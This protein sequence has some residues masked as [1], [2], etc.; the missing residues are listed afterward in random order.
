[1]TITKI[2]SFYIN[3]FNQIKNISL[4]YNNNSFNNKNY[5][6]NNNKQSLHIIYQI[7]KKI[8]ILKIYLLLINQMK[9]LI[10]KTNP[11]IP[12][13]PRRQNK[14]LYLPTLKKHSIYFNKLPINKIH[15]KTLTL[16]HSN[17][18]FPLI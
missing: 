18:Q 2:N 3:T 15:K 14:N 4:L 5:S 16:I 17:L 12:I 10:K 13:P 8:I 6:N 9:T 1:M 11:I 7:I